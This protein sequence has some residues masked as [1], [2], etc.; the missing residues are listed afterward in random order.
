[1]LGC[2]IKTYGAEFNLSQLFL[3]SEFTKY[4]GVYFRTRDEDQSEKLYCLNNSGVL[5]AADGEW[6]ALP[7][8]VLKNMSLKVGEVFVCGHSNTAPPFHYGPVRTAPIV[9]IVYTDGL[10]YDD[11]AYVSK[12]TSKR[13]NYIVH[14]F[15]QLLPD[16]ARSA[17]IDYVQDECLKEVLREED[18]Q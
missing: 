12:M 13:T 8:E 16:D 1:M 4:T 7:K 15:N 2:Q 5:I 3:L 18:S 9:E 11:D 17:I 6:H 10:F 14:D